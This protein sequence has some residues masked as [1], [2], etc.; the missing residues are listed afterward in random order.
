MTMTGEIAPGVVEVEHTAD[1]GM[2]VRASSLQQLFGRAATGMMALVRDPDRGDLPSSEDSSAPAPVFAAEER[3]I[4]LER[5]DADLAGLLVRWLRELLYLQEVNGFVYGD[6]EFER[7]DASG[8][9]AR[10]RADP[11]ASPPIRE[12]KGVTYH[13][14]EVEKRDGGWRARVIFDL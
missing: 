12:L 1:L 2:E 4:E 10:V 11:N 5:G 14:L 13:G 8:L 6:A 3:V 9:R 7:L